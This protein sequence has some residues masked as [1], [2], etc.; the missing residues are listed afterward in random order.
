[1]I[2]LYQSNRTIGIAEMKRAATKNNISDEVETK[3]LCTARY[4]L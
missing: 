1:M 4:I 2:E 3:D